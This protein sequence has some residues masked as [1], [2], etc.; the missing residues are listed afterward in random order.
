[1]IAESSPPSIRQV[2]KD[3]KGNWDRDTAA[4]AAFR[5]LKIWYKKYQ[6]YRKFE[7]FDFFKPIF[8]DI[9]MLKRRNLKW[10]IQHDRE[11]KRYR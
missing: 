2:L 3:V 6:P 7:V 8:E 4:K 10:A 1:V 11:Q 9:E 5:N